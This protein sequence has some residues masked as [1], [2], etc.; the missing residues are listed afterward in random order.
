MAT[1][2]ATEVDPATGS[3]L[4]RSFSLFL[5]R[6]PDN[7][8]HSN[9]AVV[10]HYR[11]TFNSS[12]STTTSTQFNQELP[13]FFCLDTLT[14]G[15]RNGGRRT[16]RRNVENEETVGPALKRLVKRAGVE[17]KPGIEGDT[18]PD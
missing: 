14:R 2:E 10:K 11:V 4:W 8:S 16:E 15:R 1:L 9:M 13:L 6:L 7:N 5:C 17:N 18:G 3:A 12:Q